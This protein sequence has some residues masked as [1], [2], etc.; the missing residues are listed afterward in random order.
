MN[1]TSERQPGRKEDREEGYDSLLARLERLVG[2]LE[3]GQ[4][5]LEA[6]I[7]RFAEGMRLAS[8]ATR[9][10]DEAERRVEALVRNA[11]GSEE[12]VP[13]TAEAAKASE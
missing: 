2:E 13:F 10:L 5:G 9:K 3:S 8:E 11:D 12:A 1:Q 7:E 4:L 6:S